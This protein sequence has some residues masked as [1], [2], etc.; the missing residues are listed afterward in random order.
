MALDKEK[1]VAGIVG[2]IVAGFSIGVGFMIAQKTMGKFFHKKMQNEDVKV[3]DAV[4]EG[5]TEGLKQAKVEQDAANFA[6]M[7]AATMKK[8]RGKQAMSQ[9]MMSQR[10]SG[11]MGFDGNPN[12][13]SFNSDPTGF[14]GSPNSMLNNF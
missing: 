7:N 4:K 9:M 3:A 13:M 12:S 11:F 1:L 6:A 8:S 5:V 10:G 14:K 2:G